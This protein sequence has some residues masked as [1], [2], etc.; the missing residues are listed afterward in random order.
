MLQQFH[1]RE[2]LHFFGAV[3]NEYL[4][5]L[6][7]NERLKVEKDYEKIKQCIIKWLV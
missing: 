5:S 1:N 4:H 7:R 6:R 2:E 3:F